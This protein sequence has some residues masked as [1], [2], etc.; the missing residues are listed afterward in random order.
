MSERGYFGR[1]ARAVELLWRPAF[2]PA[3][4]ALS[5]VIVAAF[6]AD[7]QNREM[8]RQGLRSDVLSQLGLVRAKLEGS[9]NGNI[10]LARG[11]VA[12]IS[13]EP[14]MTQERFSELSRHL[15]TQRSQLRHIAA[16]PDLVVRMV[17]PLE[18]NERAIGLDYNTNEAQRAAALRARDTGEMVLAGPLDLVQGGIG[19]VAR[20]PVYTGPV[21]SGGFWGIVAAV[22]DV[23]SLYAESGLFDPRLPIE[24]AIAGRDATG[25]D[26]EIFYGRPGIFADDPVI[27]DVQLA[28]G[29]W[30][31]AA[32]PK[33]GW[34][35]APPFVWLLRLAMV[36]AGG[37]IVVPMVM[38]GR[39]VE[40]RRRNIFELRR[41]ERQLDRLSRR[42][43]LAL[44]ASKVGVWEY[45][46]TTGRL[47]WDDR[48]NELYG[49]PR[50]NGA[51]DYQSWR[52]ALHPK[53]LA[54]AE[55]DFSHAIEETG[56][57]NS[58][59]RLLLPDGAVRHIRAIGAV[60][61]EANGDSVIV[62]VNWDVTADVA[63]NEDLR[64]AK[65]LTEARN[66]ELEHAQ[67]RIE[68]NALHDSLT[69]LPNRRYL[70]Q[71]LEAL[72]SEPRQPEAQTALLHIDLD[73]F[74]QI[75]DTLGHAAGDAMLVHAAGVLKANIR[76]DDFVAR[77]GG[78]EFVVLCVIGHGDDPEAYL[79]ALADRII[80]Q[81]R[82][83]VR[84]HG[85]EC[86]FGVSVGIALRNE[87]EEPKQLLVNADIALYRA[88][89]RG[90]DRYQFFN[91]ALQAEIVSTK[92]TADEILNGLERGEFV[93]HYQPQF[94]AR[95]REIIGVEALVRWDHPSRGLLAPVHFLSVAEE[96]NVVA[97]I[98]RIILEQALRDFEIWRRQ[99]LGIP[100]VSVNVSARRLRD[101][102][103]V[104]S[105]RG[106]DIKPGTVSFELVE[107]IFLD[108]NDE[109][110]T[111]NVDHL[112]DL[113]IGIE[114]D[115]F[116]TGYASI[117]SLLKL[118]PSRLKIDRQLVRP[119]T[120]SETQR[121]LV[122]SIID[123][124][125]SLNIA[126]LA[127]G[128]ETLEHAE[129]LDRL[130]C[131]ALQGYAFA[132]PMASGA[133]A[134]FARTRRWLEAS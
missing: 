91:R 104:A 125:K 18:G 17:Y 20:F 51:R 52:R 19:L 110:V 95:T 1:V 114:I 38:T 9:I 73:R 115:D 89:S 45:N 103:L 67:E 29:S 119:I 11:L 41:R 120:R 27:A 65:T 124:G 107:S 4:V 69:G 72:A 56:Q 76:H 48:M 92:R 15:L 53:D 14:D 108:E 116:G 127:E 2:I 64:R 128:V 7:S 123:I 84:Y 54:R 90:R 77:V 12:A 16:A 97:S 98:D 88:K 36:F 49:L 109:F 46:I 111:W 58:D 106:L 61:G 28:T 26:G 133:L 33:N 25:R 99:G 118:R 80:E 37:L 68:Y 10:Q 79:A 131:D 47:I 93:A 129:I 60:Y 112:K 57:Y 96:L 30:R 23:S 43:G 85:H 100:A 121:A 63:L 32:I 3:A 70:D 78:D 75:N 50:D 6:Y 82:R 35:E 62:G 71:R 13:T 113:G 86:R 81:M 122:H 22:I 87:D 59:Y 130:G 39:L 74:K 40:E 102:E 42:L 126:V 132:K 34:D 55:K 83:P 66:Q 8:Y 105:L 44:D 94:D 134:E 5:V 24:V 101:E 21:E 117:V 31:V